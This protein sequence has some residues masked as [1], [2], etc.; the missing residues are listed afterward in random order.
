VATGKKLLCLRCVEEM[1]NAGVRRLLE[2]KNWGVFG[3]VGELFVK[4]LELETWVCPSCG[5]VEFFAAPGERENI[6][7]LL[8]EE[9]G[10]RG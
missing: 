9:G 1:E 6:L 10:R 2:G 5:K 4:R 3:F 8:D 7:D